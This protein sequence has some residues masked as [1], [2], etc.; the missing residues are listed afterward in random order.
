MCQYGSVPGPTAGTGG[1]LQVHHSG[2]QRD[3]SDAQ[4]ASEHHGGAS[5]A[6]Q[7]QERHNGA[8]RQPGQSDSWENLV[9][10]GLGYTT[11]NT[12]PKDPWNI[13]SGMTSECPGEA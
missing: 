1:I 2:T 13:P 8:V 12:V 5:A 7:H 10:A 4:T 9:T 6:A 3:L 11:K